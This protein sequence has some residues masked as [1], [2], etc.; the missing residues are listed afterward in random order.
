MAEPAVA[1]AESAILAL[2]TVN[3]LSPAGAIQPQFRAAIDWARELAL[4]EKLTDGSVRLTRTG[5]LLSNELFVRLLP[6]AA[7]PAA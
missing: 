6:Q 3:G 4:L 5:R 2:R 1:A 7:A